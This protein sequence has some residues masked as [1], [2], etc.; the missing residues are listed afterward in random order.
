MTTIAQA[1]GIEDLTASLTTALTGLLAESLR[2]K[3]I[4]RSPSAP[5]RI[6]ARVYQLLRTAAL[7]PA[8]RLSRIV[9][10][11]MTT[12]IAAAFDAAGQVSRA[13][14]DELYD[15]RAATAGV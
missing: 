7:C 15:I 11:G 9:H 12:D 3:P 6:Q 4:E 14:F 2:E 5:D 1:L 10:D 8:N 13:A